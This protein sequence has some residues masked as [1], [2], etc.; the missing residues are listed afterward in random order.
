MSEQ[1]INTT[2][3]TS[4]ANNS[5]RV[6]SQAG[7]DLIKAFEGI[8]D[9]DPKTVNLDA[10]LCQA[11]VATI[12]WGHAVVWDGKQLKGQAGLAKSKQIYPNGIT[13]AEAEQLLKLDLHRFERAVI[14]LVKV[15]ITNNQFAALVSFAFNVGEG[16][17]GKST[18][19]KLVNAKEFLN[20][21]YQFARWNKAAGKPS[22]GLTRRREAERKLF[23]TI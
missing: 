13:M 20:A 22:N 5:V 3:T 7:V 11:N 12:G 2:S 9:G 1:A 18:L 19:L 16:A 4:T 14:S 6:I 21:S 15:P 23:T 17:F 10:Y 8:E